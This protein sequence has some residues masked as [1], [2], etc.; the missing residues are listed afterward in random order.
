MLHAFHQSIS[1]SELE[2]SVL[3]KTGKKV[4]VEQ[5][6]SCV[7]APEGCTAQR[8]NQDTK[9]SVFLNEFTVQKEG[10]RNKVTKREICQG[11]YEEILQCKRH[12]T[13]KICF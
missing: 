2:F 4:R 6:S 11:K 5:M 13:F 9:L 10:E 7:L 3:G 8:T 12:R 1:L